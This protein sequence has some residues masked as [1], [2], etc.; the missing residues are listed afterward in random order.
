MYGAKDEDRN[1]G[2]YETRTYTRAKM[3]FNGLNIKIKGQRFFQKP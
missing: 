3:K 2:T 1:T